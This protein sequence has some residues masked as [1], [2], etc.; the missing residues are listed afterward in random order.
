[1]PTISKHA[2]VETSNI[3]KDVVIG[4]FTHVG[5]DVRI[6]A[7]TI[8]ED[9]VIIMGRTSIGRDNHIFPGVV[10][11]PAEG[12]DPRARIKIGQA[13]SLPEPVIVTGSAKGPTLSNAI[14]TPDVDKY[15]FVLAAGW[16]TFLRNSPQYRHLIATS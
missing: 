13:N 16:P 12:D 15:H 3:A 5:P 8:I 7:G 14:S 4:A 11:G 10:I 9:N 6:A 2:T 1:M